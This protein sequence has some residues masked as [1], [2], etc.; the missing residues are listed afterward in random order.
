[1]PRLRDEFEYEIGQHHVMPAHIEYGPET[2]PHSLSPTGLIRALRTALHD[3]FSHAPQAPFTPDT[4][5]DVQEHA[6]H[7]DLGHLGLSINGGHSN[8]SPRGFDRLN[9]ES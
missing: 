4:V 6:T 7:Y 3:R 9:G 5:V 2:H 1:M 8:D